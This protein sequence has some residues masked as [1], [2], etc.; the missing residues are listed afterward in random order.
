MQ[1]IL[2]NVQC[3]D[4]NFGEYLY[5]IQNKKEGISIYFGARYILNH[6][7][8]IHL[9]KEFTVDCIYDDSVNT[10][11][12][13][14]LELLN[15]EQDYYISRL[16]VAVDFYTE[17]DKSFSIKRH[18]NQRKKNYKDYS[19]TGSTKNPHK[20]C[21]IAHYDRTSK[22]ITDTDYL[23]RFE[24]KM[25]FNQSDQFRFSNIRDDLIQKRMAEEWFFPRIADLKGITALERKLLLQSKE[26]ESEQVI[27]DTLGSQGYTKLRNK[28][29][30][31]RIRLHQYYIVQAYD[32]LFDFLIK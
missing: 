31:Q 25:F 1:I 15:H 3:R 12:K 14:V 26:I 16:D 29:R 11:R 21:C 27:R 18:G 9:Q 2:N 22:G 5:A 6:N 13:F 17:Y 23:N 10:L 32:T 28:L 7:V 20:S 24:C 19:N 4:L 8:S 30:P